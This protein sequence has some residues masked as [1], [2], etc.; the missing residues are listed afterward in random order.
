MDVS[1]DSIAVGRSEAEKRVESARALFQSI[2]ETL[3]VLL[4][5][6]RKGDGRRLRALPL[7]QA[8]LETAHVRCGEL[9]RRFNEKYGN[10]A[11][12][13]ELDL[14]AIRHEIGCRLNRLRDCR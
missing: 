2:T 9:E 4:D 10:T 8:E 7:K 13:G 1:Q 12:D 11:D 5:E 3:G 14:D 6:V